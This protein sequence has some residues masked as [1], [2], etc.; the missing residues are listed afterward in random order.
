MGLILH[1]LFQMAPSRNKT[2]EACETKIQID[3]MFVS[4]KTYPD[5]PPTYADILNME[6]CPEYDEVILHITNLPKFNEETKTH[7]LDR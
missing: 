1:C 6:R 3:I 2:K 7:E 5:L 4:G